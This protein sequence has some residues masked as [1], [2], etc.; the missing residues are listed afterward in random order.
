[1]GLYPK[2]FVGASLRSLD[3][4]KPFFHTQRNLGEEA[5]ESVYK[6]VRDKV[7]K[8]NQDKLTKGD[9]TKEALEKR[10]DAIAKRRE[11]AAMVANGAGEGAI[12][13]GTLGG[14]VGG[15]GAAADGDED[16]SVLGGVGK[17]VLTGAIGGAIPGAISA[18]V[19]GS[20]NIMDN[21]I[22]HSKKIAH[23]IATLN[24]GEVI[25]G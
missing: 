20:D 16:T 9:I 11:R 8:A 13:G 17:G 19:T 23:G 22:R 14:V 2:K 15:I 24:E 5:G 10:A 12:I 6:K 7:I 18:G 1:M 4:V 21:M 3:K 25:G